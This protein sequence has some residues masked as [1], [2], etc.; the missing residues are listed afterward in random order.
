MHLLYLTYGFNVVPFGLK[1]QLEIT[2]LGLEENQLGFLFYILTVRR[3]SIGGRW[4]DCEKTA[5]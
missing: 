5:I 2:I 4:I 3:K 1:D